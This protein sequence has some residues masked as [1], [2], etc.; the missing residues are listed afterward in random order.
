MMR[1][2][3]DTPTGAAALEFVDSDLARIGARNA[4]ELADA[5]AGR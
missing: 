3:P 2:P 1:C 4:R 5:D